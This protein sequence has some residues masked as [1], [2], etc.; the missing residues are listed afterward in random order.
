M[1]GAKAPQK[2]LDDG[3]WNLAKIKGKHWLLYEIMELFTKHIQTNP[4]KSL[5]KSRKGI[6]F[7]IDAVPYLPTN[8]SLRLAGFVEVVA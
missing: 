4:S 7:S 3:L 6:S 5:R 1:L 2:I 8:N